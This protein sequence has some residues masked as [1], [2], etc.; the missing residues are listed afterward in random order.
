MKNKTRAFFYSLIAISSVTGMGSQAKAR[1][2]TVDIVQK[3]KVVLTKENLAGYQES[4]A[5]FVEKREGDAATVKFALNIPFGVGKLASKF[6]KGVDLEEAN[7]FLERAFENKQALIAAAKKLNSDEQSIA[8]LQ[9]LLSHVSPKAIRK[10]NSDDLPALMKQFRH[11]ASKEG[12][13]PWDKEQV[14]D[15]T[16]YQIAA[17]NFMAFAIV[18]EGAPIA[19]EI[20]EEI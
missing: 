16:F 9:N 20:E 7:A 12:V 5:Q 19:G 15:E 8:Y 2:G 6:F 13:D 18:E 14:N 3:L 17:C 1:K 10:K 4:F 11:P